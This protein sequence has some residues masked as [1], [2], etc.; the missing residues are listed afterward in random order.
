MSIK[1]KIAEEKRKEQ[2][3]NAQKMAGG[4]DFLNILNK[5]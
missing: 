4:N 5:Y 3:R 2:L 1:E